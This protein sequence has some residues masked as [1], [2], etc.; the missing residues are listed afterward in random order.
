MMKIIHNPTSAAL[1]RRRLKTPPA[2]TYSFLANRERPIMMKIIHNPQNYKTSC[3]RKLPHQRSTFSTQF[4]QPNSCRRIQY[5][6][7]STNKSSKSR[8]KLY[9]ICDTLFFVMMSTIQNFLIT[10]FALGGNKAR[11][12]DFIVAETALKTDKTNLGS[13]KI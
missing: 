8:L 11:K 12:L 9:T 13:R 6:L 3:S 4:P 7:S 2:M 10:L 5:P 1:A